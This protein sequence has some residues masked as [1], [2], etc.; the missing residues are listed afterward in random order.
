MKEEN[1]HQFKLFYS[2]LFGATT[3]IKNMDAQNYLDNPELLRNLEEKLP[4]TTKN[5]WVHYKAE[6]LRRQVK[7]N[8]DAL[9]E[10]FKFELDAQFA[11][12]SAKD[13]LKKNTKA[14]V[15][16]IDSSSYKRDKW[17]HKCKGAVGHYLQDC[18][19][20]KKLVVEKRRDF[21]KQNNICFM[22]LRK[23][24]QTKVCR[25]K[26][27]LPKC[28]KCN[29]DHADVLYFEDAQKT[30]RNVDNQIA[31]VRCIQ[32][33]DVLLKIAMVVLKS[34]SKTMI[35]PAFF[36]DGSTATMIDEDLANDLGLEG[37]VSPIT[38]RWTNDIVRTDNES[39]MVKICVSSTNKNAK[40]YSLD[41]VRTGKNLALPF[42]NFNVKDVLY[43][44][45]YLDEEKLKKICY[46]QPLLL[47]GSNNAGLTVSLKTL[48]CRLNGLLECKS[49]LGW[50]IHGPIY[51]NQCKSSSL[52]VHLLAQKEE[53]KSLNELV[54][55][56]YEIE[57]FGVTNETEKLSAD[58]DAALTIMRN[59]MKKVGDRF[60]IGHL[61]KYPGKK[62]PTE[63]S[64]QMALK[65]LY[66]IEQKMDR[67]EKFAE[68]YIQRIE[69]HVMKGYAEKL[70][71]NYLK[72]TPNTYYLPHFDAH[73]PNKPGKFRWVMD[74]KAKAGEYSLND[75]LFQGPDFVP[76]LL[77]ILWRARLKPIGMNSD[78]AEMFHQVQIRPEDRDSQR[79]LFR[80]KDR[81]RAPDVYRMKAMMFGAISSPSCAQFV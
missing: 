32:T 16:A 80:G 59:T 6:L 14:T 40:L 57:N 41:N 43:L 64:K 67:N 60:E 76:P 68:E 50:T 75:L 77:A 66:L 54:K 39:R 25:N 29:K 72:D 30:I 10:W 18:S 70:T 17:C 38:Y 15:L 45:P 79:F 34:P 78:I 63:E 56:S 71:G 47:I 21:V 44:H 27:S 5:Y 61:Y 13:V 7:V 31:E 26:N 58:D 1:I 20:F 22:C 3:T 48:Q 51:E 55:E 49:R 24:H 33:C 4:P 62:F 11:G 36:D 19:E 2:K 65:R 23:G 35:V 37:N 46:V 81:N 73:N 69:D 74:A 53:D 28:S 8:I 9:G 42:Q 12:L 52:S